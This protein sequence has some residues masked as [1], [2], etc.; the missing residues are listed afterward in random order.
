MNTVLFLCTGN[1]YRSR[2]AE[3]FFNWST[4]RHGILWRAESR[5]L[6]LDPANLGPMSSHTVAR[7]HRLGIPM[8]RYK[9]LPIA[10]SHRDFEVAHHVVAIKQTEHRPMLERMFPMWLER[11]EFW[12]I[13]DLDCIGPEETIPQLEDEVMELIDRLAGDSS[14]TARS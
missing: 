8:D 6:Q 9:R 10:V 5:G 11:V 2:F 7:L 13:H 12:E 14:R 3:V 4:E 1:Y